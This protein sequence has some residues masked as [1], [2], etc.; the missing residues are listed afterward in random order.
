MDGNEDIQNQDVCLCVLYVDI[1]MKILVQR[2][3]KVSISGLIYYVRWVS[4]YIRAAGV[5]QS[6]HLEPSN[7]C[8]VWTLGSC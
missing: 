5:C 6:S 8:W 7:E 4:V 1:E 3:I 2:N